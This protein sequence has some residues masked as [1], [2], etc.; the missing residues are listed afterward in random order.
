LQKGEKLYEELSY[1]SEETDDTMHA[2][3][4]ISKT[5]QLPADFE[6]RIGELRNAAERY[7]G[8]EIRRLLKALIPSYSGYTA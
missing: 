1:A 4:L 2:D 7:D 8:Q 3:V 5:T 6:E